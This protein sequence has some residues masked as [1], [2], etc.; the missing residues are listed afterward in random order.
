MQMITE[1]LLHK[2]HCGK[3]QGQRQMNSAEED[4][5][6]DRE[7][8]RLCA[9]NDVFSTDVAPRWQDE[10]VCGNFGGGAEFSG[11][12][13][14]IGWIMGQQGVPGTDGINRLQLDLLGCN[15]LIL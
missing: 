14:C 8:T 15:V 10:T 7:Q 2:Q 11:L 4:C 6:S 12:W 13:P 1:Q 3:K 5:S 9:V